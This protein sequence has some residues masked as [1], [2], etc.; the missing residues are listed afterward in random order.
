MNLLEI[1]INIRFSKENMVKNV[2][3]G[4]NSTKIVVDESLM[5]Q[6]KCKKCG[7]ELVLKDKEDSPVGASLEY[8]C[9]N[10]V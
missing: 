5:N 1:F 3:A 6:I 9:P 4:A 8:K 10:C 7:K 2:T